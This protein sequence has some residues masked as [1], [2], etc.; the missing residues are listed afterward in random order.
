MLSDRTNMNIIHGKTAAQQVQ[1]LGTL[2]H[3]SIK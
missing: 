2:G 1:L 3:S